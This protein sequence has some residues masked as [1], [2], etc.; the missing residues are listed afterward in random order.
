MLQKL[1]GLLVRGVLFSSLIF[2]F[3]VSPFSYAGCTDYFSCNQEI[4]RV[5]G[6]ISRLRGLENTLAN[7]IAYLT[8]Q[9]YLS[10]LEIQAKQAEIDLLSGDIGELA[11][12]LD[13]IASFLA[14]QEEIFTARSRSAYVS[15]QISPLDIILGADNL[16]EVIRKIK[17][18][19]VLEQEDREVLGQM[20]ETRISF[21]EQKAAL[22]GKKADV[23]RLKA[24]V[25]AHQ[26]GLVGQKAA[27][28][29]L[30]D[31]TRG[32]EAE[33]QRL[34]AKL[35]AERRAIIE[36]LRS[37]GTSLGPVK[38]GGQIARQGNS[39]CS[40][41]PHIHY[42]VHRSSDLAPL[43]PC[44]FVDVVGGRCSSPYWSDWWGTVVSG[45]LFTP[46]GLSNYLTQAYWSSH[47]ALDVVSQDGWVYA[48]AD[49]EAY[50][51]QDPAWFVSYCRDTLGYPYNG[52]GYG[53]RID[54]ADGTVT[55]YWH[56]QP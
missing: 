56:I 17:Y 52:T 33:Y 7:Q 42:S 6:E 54:H 3:A 12:R 20:Y 29:A 10:E 8:N 35:E 15:N 53:I 55:S 5:K 41:G 14:Y 25:E 38:M 46:A 47:Q 28:A 49:G 40:S 39:G 18:L 31:Q 24:E 26:A 43:S 48:S 51:V 4:E 2:F 32:E 50:L 37:R 16:D 22:E 1:P 36:A 34:L 21:N 19:R 23:E 45:S 11:L 27:K 44:G 9:I 13:R 30:L